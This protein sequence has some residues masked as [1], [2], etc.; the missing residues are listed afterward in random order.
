MG[1]HWS[2]E[3]QLRDFSHRVLEA[4]KSQVRESR[5]GNGRAQGGRRESEEEWGALPSEA[6]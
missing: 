6:H 5:G 1:K 2:Q 4:D 3:D